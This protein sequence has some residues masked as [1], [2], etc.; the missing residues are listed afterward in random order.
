M[1]RHDMTDQQWAII[2]EFFT[3]APAKTGRPR[4][5]TRQTFNGIIHILKTGSAWRDLPTE[6]GPWTTTYGYFRKWRDDGS[7]DRAQ[8][9]LLEFLERKGL[10]NHDQWN[11][12]GTSI[13]ATRAAAGASDRSK[14]TTRGNLNTTLWAALA[15]V[16]GPKSTS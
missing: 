9:A 6:Y 13:R 14:K 10:L 4:R 1:G 16:S 8:H 2:G 12:D 15:A 5:D 7:F 3:L 11:I